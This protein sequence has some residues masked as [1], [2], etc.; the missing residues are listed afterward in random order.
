MAQGEIPQE[1]RHFILNYIDTVPHLESLLLLWESR[2]KA[3]TEAELA[4]RVY[5]P[6][7]RARAILQDL[8]RLKLVATLPDDPNSYRYDS[9]W[10]VSGEMMSQVA[11]AYRRQL[12]QVATLIHSKASFAVREFARAFQIK[13]E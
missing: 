9:G 5:V 11:L 8:M 7:E 13:K 3:W 2:P 10:D 12:V 6:V 4:H 1:V